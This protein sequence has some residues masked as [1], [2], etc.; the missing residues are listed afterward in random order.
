MASIQK[1]FI[2]GAGGFIGKAVAAFLNEQGIETCGIDFVADPQANVIAA[3]LFEVEKWRPLLED[4][5]AVLHTAAVVSNA[6]DEDETWRVN[7]SGTRV[8]LEAASAS[9]RTR[10]FIHLSSVA[11][12]GFE[13]EGV[14]DET[15]ALRACGQPYRDTKIASEHLVLNYQS[16]GDIDCCIIRPA[17][18][19]GPGSRPWVVLPIQQMKIRKFL[20]PTEGMFGPVYVD[21]LV[22]GIHQALIRPESS[23]QIFILSGFGEVTNLEYFGRLAR[24]LGLARVPSVPGRLAIAGTGIFEKAVHLLGKT[25]DI[26]PLTMIMLSRPSADYSHAKA[27][28]C[29][30]TSHRSSWTKACSGAKP[31]CVHRLCSTDRVREREYVCDKSTS[32]VVRNRRNER[33][34]S[35]VGRGLS[36]ARRR[37]R[38]F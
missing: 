20:V 37:R 18:V 4:S 19:Y 17:D 9:A 30:L 33:A 26:N 2:T 12:L 15:L 10:R 36:G 11:A 27:G 22:R 25:T 24:M 38:N 35:G 31:G 7:V 6:L 13:H 32:Y 3:D 5:D 1:V 21:D 14:M 16:S 29:C 28:G 8:V 34:G 23:G